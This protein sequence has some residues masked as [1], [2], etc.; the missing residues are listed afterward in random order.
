VLLEQ[1]ERFDT[2]GSGPHQEAIL[3]ESALQQGTQGRLI[4]SQQDALSG[5]NSVTDGAG[6]WIF[7]GGKHRLQS[8]DRHLRNG[9]RLHENLLAT[10]HRAKQWTG[11]HTPILGELIQGC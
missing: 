4:L 6:I 11:G 1:G 9:S 2:I 10:A 3:A 7:P 8:Y 5:R